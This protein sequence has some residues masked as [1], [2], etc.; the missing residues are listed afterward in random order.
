MC[1][2]TQGCKAEQKK[3]NRSSSRKKALQN[4]YVYARRGGRGSMQRPSFVAYW[5]LRKN[6]NA[7]GKSVILKFV[8][9]VHRP[10]LVRLCTQ[11]TTSYLIT[12]AIPLLHSFPFSPWEIPHLFN[13]HWPISHCKP[14]SRVGLHVVTVTV[15]FVHS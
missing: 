14:A 12:T 13:L 7:K 6:A 10:Y 4:P 5:I 2:F 8:Y 11:Y 1:C 3:K 9:C 15:N